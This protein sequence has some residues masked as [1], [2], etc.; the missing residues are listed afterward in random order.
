MTLLQAKGIQRVALHFWHVGAARKKAD[1]E[2]Q[3][4]PRRRLHQKLFP[5]RLRCY[6]NWS[7]RALA[8]QLRGS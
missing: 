7:A 6:V 1:R 5:S 2:A 3:A 4:E 8:T